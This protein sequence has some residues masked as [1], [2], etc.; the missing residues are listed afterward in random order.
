MDPT[1]G[2]M[3]AT[4]V[5]R[6][7]ALRGTV[8]RLL[9]HINIPFSVY[10]Y[11]DL[12]PPLHSYVTNIVQKT[13]RNDVS[14]KIL[15]DHREISTVRVGS[16]GARHYLFEEMKSKHD[17][18]ASFDDDMQI[19]KGWY[20]AMKAA[21]A[22]HPQY[23]V[24]TGVMKG[25]QGGLLTAGNKM[26]IEGDQLIRKRIRSIEGRYH[27]AD[28]GPIG[29]LVLC[30]KALTSEVKIPRDIYTLE[31][32]AFFLELRKLGIHQTVVTTEAVT[33]HRAVPTANS[34]RWP[35]K[36]PEIERYF[37]EHYGVWIRK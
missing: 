29:C 6:K 4:T 7:A 23:C 33:V 34:N 20:P 9:E 25:P 24:F 21:I 18:L 35:E 1:I 16:A 15:N 2:I 28:W 32:A 36:M 13:R 22:E 10:I 11:N 37:R 17:M 31:D 26:Y 19:G 12:A 27:L 14:V 3:I 8:M 5:D 30:R